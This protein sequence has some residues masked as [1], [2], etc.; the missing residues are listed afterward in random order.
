MNKKKL[1]PKKE[2]PLEKD[3]DEIV[4]EVDH[5]LQIEEQEEEEFEIFALSSET[6][7]EILM[8]RDVHFGGNFDAMLEYYRNE[9]KGIHPAFSIEMIEKLAAL[10]KEGNQN[11]AAFV[12]TGAELEKVA[13][14]KDAYKKLRDL[15]EMTNEKRSPATL[16]ADLVLSEEEEPEAE[17]A[18]IVAEKTDTVPL[19]MDLIRSEEFYDPLF[20]GYGQAPILAGKC[21]GLIGDKRGIIALFEAMNQGD[22][23][24]EEILLK[25]LKSIGTPAKEFL[26]KVL[27]GR[28]LNED[29]ETAALALL[30][31]T[32]DP[33]VSNACLNL[34]KE[35]DVQKDLPL[36]TY[37][38]LCCEGLKDPAKR[39]TFLQFTNDPK[40]PNML[41]RDI[42]TVTKSWEEPI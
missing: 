19:L 13:R 12:L 15:Y 30:E 37:L 24:S 34:L 22:F 2:H 14:A 17:I 42:L 23:F 6:E 25:A 27:H 32:E 41:K 36:A 21:L 28:P 3:F 10:E 20:P 33:E 26:L 11:L 40:L 39:E 8:H 16:I 4:Q 29:N 38:I 9:G 31:F 35:T 18:A 1:S 7:N 5:E